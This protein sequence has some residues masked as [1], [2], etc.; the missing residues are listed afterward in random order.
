M[1]QNTPD[2]GARCFDRIERETVAATCGLSEYA[3]IAIT[4]RIEHVE[5]LYEHVR[6]VVGDRAI[7]LISERLES[8]GAE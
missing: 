7:R 3:E 2:E 6:A 1:R 8:I 5:K 4:A